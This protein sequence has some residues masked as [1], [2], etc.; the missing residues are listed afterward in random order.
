MLLETEGLGLGGRLDGLDFTLNTGELL[1][2]LGE[3]G[4]GKS[5]LLECLAGWLKPERGVIRFH[6][7]ALDRWSVGELARRRALLSQQP[8]MPFGLT[9]REVLEL[10]GIP[11]GL[12]GTALEQALGEMAERLDIGHLL[13]RSINRLSGGEQQRVQLARTLLQIWPEINPEGSLLLLDEPLT[14]L[15]LRHMLLLMQQLKALVA[16]GFT[17]VLSLHDINLANQYAD[18]VMLLKQG[19][20]ICLAPPNEALSEERL[21]QVFNVRAS[22]QQTDAS[23]WYRFAL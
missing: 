18:R 8:Q 20:Q 3:N 10:A 22:L 23:Q 17:V 21:S 2:L 12:K 16:G 14:G 11:L 4:A 6:G 13:E 5:T 19:R 1:V 15:D 9:A 7:R